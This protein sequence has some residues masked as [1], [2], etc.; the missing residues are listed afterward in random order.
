[1][2]LEPYIYAFSGK[3]QTKINPT[4]KMSCGTRCSVNLIITFWKRI[5]LHKYNYFSS[6]EAGNCVSNSSFKWMKHIPK[7]FG[8]IRV[9]IYNKSCCCGRPRADVNAPLCVRFKIGHW[10]YIAYKLY[11]AHLCDYCRLQPFC[12]MFEKPDSGGHWKT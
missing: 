8:S 7:R 1:M 12:Q 5:L 3:L 6:F 9:N 10:P 4:K 11:D 2:L